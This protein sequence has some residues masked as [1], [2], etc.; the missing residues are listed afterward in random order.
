MT[1]ERNGRRARSPSVA[2]RLHVLNR[3]QTTEGRVVAPGA[4]VWAH[5]ARIGTR[6]GFHPRIGSRICARSSVGISVDRAPVDACIEDRAGSTAFVRIA[7]GLYA[8]AAVVHNQ[9]RADN[10]ARRAA[11]G[12]GVALA[13]Q[14]ARRFAAELGILGCASCVHALLVLARQA[15]AARAA[16]HV[17]AHARQG[18]RHAA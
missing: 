9:A 1:E 4:D 8:A 14:G 17:T 2:A 18:D 10:A 3:L 11:L 7:V 5:G 12:T 16:V 13:V 15:R 6:I